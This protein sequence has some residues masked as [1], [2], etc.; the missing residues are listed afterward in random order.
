[1]GDAAAHY[2]CDFEYSVL[3]QY[4]HTVTPW[5]VCA[6]ADPNVLCKCEIGRAHV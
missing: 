5:G 6:R 3:T 4:Q 2:A 1:M